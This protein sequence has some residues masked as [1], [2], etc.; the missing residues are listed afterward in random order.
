MPERDRSFNTTVTPPTMMWRPEAATILDL[1][2]GQKIGQYRVEGVLGRGGMGIV[3]KGHHDALDRYVAIK[4]ISGLARDPVSADRFLREGRAASR[5]RHANILT[6]FDYGEV[7]GVPFMVTEFIA[8]GS[9]SDKLGNGPLQPGEAL[10]YLRGVGGGID[11]AHRAQIIHRDIKPSNVL[12]SAG[13]DAILADFGLARLLSHDAQRS[14]SG[15]ITGTVAYM[16]PEQAREIAV[17][18]AADIYS[19]ATMAFELLTGQVPFPGANVLDV[20]LSQ[21]HEQPPAPS[22][23]NPKLNP[24]VDEVILRG[25]AKDPLQRWDSC[26][27]MV[28]ALQNALR[29]TPTLRL[30][31]RPMAEVALLPKATA[32]ARGG[33]VLWGAV[34]G[35]AFLLLGTVGFMTVGKS[36]IHSGKAPVASTSLREGTP[37]LALSTPNASQSPKNAPSLEP[38]PATV[39]SNATVGPNPAPTTNPG[40]A[41]APG[42]T[43][44]PTG[45]ATNAPVL[46]APVAPTQPSQQPIAQPTPTAAPSTPPSTAPTTDLQSVTI[47]SNCFLL[48]CTMTATPTGG[49]GSYTY[50]W[51]SVNTTTSSAGPTDSRN[52]ATLTFAVPGTY[53]VRC[54]VTDTVGGRTRDSTATVTVP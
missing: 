12:L 21:I 35:V 3:Y 32:G 17:G 28:A 42:P 14:Q 34:A 31:P 26:A 43:G 9:L 53:R 11:Y 52:P 38:S 2:P 49:S 37:G 36:L 20:L 5:M 44:A 51:T 46:V 16:A 6:V 48:T 29:P 10:D 45:A 15:F 8:G 18:P 1:E 7:D 25:L 13:G 24:E 4:V 39:P 50:L 40:A 47:S 30:V 22:S 54:T 41:P 33:Q 27:E 23:I 19:F